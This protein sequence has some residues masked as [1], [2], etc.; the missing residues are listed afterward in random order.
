[1][2]DL[3]GGSGKVTNYLIDNIYQYGGSFNS[4]DILKKFKKELPTPA[5]E[6]L[7]EEQQEA[8]EIEIKTEAVQ[9]ELTREELMQKAQEKFEELKKNAQMQ[10][11]FELRVQDFEE[12]AEEIQ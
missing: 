8:S 2:I 12:T 9:P 7:Q 4:I 11:E 5:S 3:G 6:T 10:G 1:M